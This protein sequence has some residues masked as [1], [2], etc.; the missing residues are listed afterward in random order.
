MNALSIRSLMRQLRVRP[1]LVAS[2]LIGG[3]VILLLP[4]LTQMH[5]A[6]RL[7]IGWNVGAC[8]YLVLAGVMMSRSTRERMLQR[9]SAED[10]GQGMILALVIL[11]AITCLATIV[12]ELGVV[13]AMPNDAQRS[14]HIALA[15]LTIASAWAFTH[16]MFAL[17][18][19]HDYYAARSKGQPS[20]LAF[21][22]DENTK[23][24]DEPEYSDFLYFA[25][26]IGTACATADVSITNK[27][28]RRISLVHC[29]LA[30]A[31]NTTV[32]ALTI[33]IAASLI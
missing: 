27:T 1:R 23:N 3:V 17:H 31:F 26:V 10:E 7:I 33:N 19:A 30:F 6:T 11:A 9:A 4:L 29:V 13:K 2:A 32:L 16:V 25:F 12:V 21:P 18:Y 28:M 14:G 5:L 20:G 24:K 8:L 15:V 22:T